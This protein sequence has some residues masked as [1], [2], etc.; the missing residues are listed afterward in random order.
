[1]QKTI[2]KIDENK[3][4]ITEVQPVETPIDTELLKSEKADLEAQI[5]SIQ[6]QADQ[7]IRHA[8][9]RILDIENILSQCSQIKE[10]NKKTLI[11]KD[12]EVPVK[13]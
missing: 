13:I 7:D 9:E 3:F 6:Q 4:V 10:L 2:T 12:S 8:T 11:S 1:M 5:E